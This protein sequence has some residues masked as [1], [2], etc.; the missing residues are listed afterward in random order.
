M[1]FYIT[2]TI[3]RLMH[4]ARSQDN[5]SMKGERTG[6]AGGKGS[7]VVAVFYFLTNT[8]CSRLNFLNILNFTFEMD[9]VYL[10]RS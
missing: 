8:G 2:F 10:K 4:K 1:I 7:K 6:C 3:G 9:C 5:G